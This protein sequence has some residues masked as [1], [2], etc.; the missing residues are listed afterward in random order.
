[1]TRKPDGSDSSEASSVKVESPRS[2][3]VVTANVPLTFTPN[4]LLQA[5]SSY[6]AAQMTVLEANLFGQVKLTEFVGQ[7]WTL[8]D[9]SRVAKGLRALATHFNLVA[10]WVSNEI[11]KA[12]D[13][14]K[15]THVIVYK[16]F[17]RLAKVCLGF[18]SRFILPS[19]AL[20]DPRT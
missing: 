7:R 15:H 8:P 5:N 1:M 18:L 10:Q 17:I 2:K 16:K 20:A 13:A 4:T 6:I 12:Y 19:R 14:S 3:L 9:S 11:L